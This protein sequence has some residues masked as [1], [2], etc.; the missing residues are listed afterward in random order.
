MNVWNGEDHRVRIRFR[1]KRQVAR[2][3]G[4]VHTIISR[5]ASYRGTR[6][7]TIDRACRG[8]WHTF[9]IGRRKLAKRFLIEIELL[10]RLGI[11]EVE[12][13]GHVVEMSED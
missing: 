9:K 7:L 8:K 11:V 12:L 2:D 13:D 4:T 5:A 3:R 1:D 10:A 6:R